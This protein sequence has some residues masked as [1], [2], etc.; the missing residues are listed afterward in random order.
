[1]NEFFEPAR[2]VHLLRAQWAECWREYLWFV[3]IAAIVDIIFMLIFF[4]GEANGALHSFQFDGQITWYCLGLFGSGI[5]FA[6]RHF[7]HLVQAGP[8]LTT[9]MR[10]ASNFEK[11]LLA[12][13]L[14][15]L[16][17]PLV[18][19]L[20]YS[21]LNFPV[22]ELARHWVASCKTCIDK[23]NPVDFS[24]YIPFLTAG[25]EARS[26]QSLHLFYKGQ[27]F[28][29]LM[30]WTLQALIVSGTLFFKRSPI[31]RTVLALFGLF[32]LT[33]WLGSSPERGAFWS[34]GVDETVPS[35]ALESAISLAL[36]VG[37]P[38]ILWLSVY[39]H[40]TEREVA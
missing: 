1:M 12:F 24:F 23:A 33:L 31:L 10:P 4:S 9:L 2:F 26:A 22:V 21:L 28:F 16:L 11:W 18:Y 25:Q 20:G 19:T 15:G 29:V 7:K 5:I 34:A 13:L 32:M 27:L 40:L 36:W 17:Y 6:G 30:L 38:V 39:F 35:S 8:A 37:L 14:I 3:G